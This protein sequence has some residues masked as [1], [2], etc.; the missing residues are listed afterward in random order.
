MRLILCMLLVIVFACKKNN[1]ISNPVVANEIVLPEHVVVDTSYGTDIRHKMDIYLPKGRNTIN[2]HTLMLIHGGQWT[3]GDKIQDNALIT[4]LKTRLP[5][6]AFVSI[7]YRLA[8]NGANLFP[9]QE[10]DVSQAIQFYR[11]SS[12]AVSVSPHIILYGENAGAH[13]ALLAAT[14]MGKPSVSAAIALNAPTDLIEIYNSNFN[15]DLVTQLQLVTGTTPMLSNV[16]YNSSPLFQVKANSAAVLHFHSQLN[17]VI[18]LSQAQRFVN[19]LNSFSISNTF[20][21]LNNESNQI[22]SSANSFIQN[23]LVRFLDNKALYR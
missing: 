23:E 21:L 2:T 14:K 6:F 8:N 10:N 13:L 20:H 5:A 1:G 4:Q 15:T 9:T 18:A 3:N 11:Q 22:S 17:S 12:N 19:Q 7:N 16:Y